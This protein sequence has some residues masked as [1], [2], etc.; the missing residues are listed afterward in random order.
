VPYLSPRRMQEELRR[1]E[2]TARTDAGGALDA[3]LA[4]RADVPKVRETASLTRWRDSVVDLYCRLGRHPEALQFLKGLGADDRA[5]AALAPTPGMVDDVWGRSARHREETFRARAGDGQAEEAWRGLWGA[6]RESGASD[7][8]L[9]EVRRFAR[10]RISQRLGALKEKVAD[11]TRGK[12]FGPALALVAE[13]R[14][15]LGEWSTEP[16]QATELALREAEVAHAELSSE[17]ATLETRLANARVAEQ[18]RQIG[19]GIAGLLGRRQ[20]EDGDRGRLND[21]RERS[22]ARWERLCYDE[23]RGAL[24]DRIFKSLGGRVETYLDLSAPFGEK[25]PAGRKRAVQ[26][27]QAWLEGVARPREY[28]LTAVRVKDLPYPSKTENEWG[29]YDP[30]VSV[31]FAGGES[32]P[33]SRRGRA[34]S[35]GLLV[36]QVPHEQP[37]HLARGPAG[38]AGPLGRRGR[39]Q[40][41]VHGPRPAGRS[42]CPSP[43]R[44]PR[45]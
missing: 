19:L 26:D 21:L 13:A 24:T 3:L 14:K 35:G 16:R 39:G 30:Y 27:L 43:P 9:T 18:S 23:V 5:D 40:G 29:G 31:T 33:S 41:A 20:L 12:Q 2:G 25:R 1:A 38:R 7:A 37:L 34:T 36:L 8:Y 32:R 6:T 22:L 45:R 44:A 10:D 4:L 15:E 11:E 28:V 42:V 17:A